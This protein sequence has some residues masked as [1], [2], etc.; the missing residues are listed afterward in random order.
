MPKSRVSPSDDDDDVPVTQILG[1]QH[2]SALAAAETKR[3]AAEAA[4]GSGD[5][6][7]STRGDEDAAP[8]RGDTV[9]GYEANPADGIVAILNPRATLPVALLP[10]Y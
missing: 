1:G 7:G 10:L 3:T 6:G 2:P 9:S 4:A 8:A 5:S